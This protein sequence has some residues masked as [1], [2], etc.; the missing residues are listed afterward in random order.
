M[1]TLHLILA[2]WL[3]LGSTAWAATTGFS[4]PA[5]LIDCPCV[6]GRDGAAPDWSEDF[7]FKG[8]YD[9]EFI[10]YPSGAIERD[11]SSVGNNLS[12]GAGIAVTT[13][14]AFTRQQC[15]ALDVQSSG[16]GQCPGPHHSF[17]S[18]G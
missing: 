10:N 8:V 3:A 17:S 2:A 11:A 12:A 7:W 13:R 9:M 4:R 18:S 5:T 1:R 16:P 6:A 15:R 14:A